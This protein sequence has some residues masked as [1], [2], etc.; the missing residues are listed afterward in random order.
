MK[1]KAIIRKAFKDAFFKY[2]QGGRGT[3]LA[4][5][6]HYGNDQRKHVMQRLRVILSWVDSD[7]NVYTLSDRELFVRL[8]KQ[9]EF[10]VNY[11]KGLDYDEYIMWKYGDIDH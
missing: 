11:Y 8:V 7:V 9:Y 5:T 2:V 3:D 6:F 1:K 10:L 4:W